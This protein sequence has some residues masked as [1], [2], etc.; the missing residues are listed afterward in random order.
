MFNPVT[1]SQ[2]FD[3]DG[4]FI[5]YWVP[6]LRDMDSKRIHQPGDGRPVRYPAPVVDLKTSRKAAIEA[7]QALK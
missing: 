2:R 7:F 3:P 5:R 1:Q 6:E 4:T